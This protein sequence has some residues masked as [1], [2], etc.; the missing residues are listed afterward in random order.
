ML[1]N[2]FTSMWLHPIIT[3]QEYIPER[4]EVLNADLAVV[5]SLLLLWFCY[6]ADRYQNEYLFA[7]AQGITA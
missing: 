7:M 4:W 2:L 1:H 5:W 6:S 3:L